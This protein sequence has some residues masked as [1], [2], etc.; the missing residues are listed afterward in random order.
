VIFAAI[1]LQPVVV[2][3]RITLRPVL[4]LLA[5]GVVG[6]LSCVKED[7]ALLAADSTE[8]QCVE[9]TVPGDVT[10]TIGTG[11]GQ[12]AITRGHGVTIP[13][14]TFDPPP[15]QVRISELRGRDVGFRMVVTPAAPQFGQDVR[16]LISLANCTP[17]QVGDTARWNI[18]KRVGAGGPGVALQT[19]RQGNILSAVT[20]GNSFFIVAD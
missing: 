2:S 5:L 9:V 3:M 18:H 4:L 8:L 10:E 16:I 17:E 19:S 6:T 14:G 12:V 11:G 7:V 13:A 15:R 20:R 1:Q